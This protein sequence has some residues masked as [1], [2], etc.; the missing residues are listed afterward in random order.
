M[1]KVT[2]LL[3]SFNV[4]ISIRQMFERGHQS[5]KSRCSH[6]QPTVRCRPAL[7][8]FDLKAL[9][10]VQ[11]AVIRMR[12]ATSYE[13]DARL[14]FCSGVELSKPV[15]ILDPQ[16]AMPPRSRGHT[17]GVTAQEAQR[18]CSSPSEAVGR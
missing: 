14:S 16:G 5:S 7:G 4:E 18:S 12:A 2:T 3:D 1:P 17:D 6:G 9:Q 15:G 8:L 11:G 13:A 10:F